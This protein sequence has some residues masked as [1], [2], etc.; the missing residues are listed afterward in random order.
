MAQCCDAWAIGWFAKPFQSNLLS[1]QTDAQE[2]DNE[3]ELERY[4]QILRRTL[5]SWFLETSIPRPLKKALLQDCPIKLSNSTI[6]PIDSDV[7]QLC[8]GVPD[9]PLYKTLAQRMLLL[10]KYESDYNLIPWLL[11]ASDLGFSELSSSM[12]PQSPPPLSRLTPKTCAQYF[13]TSEMNHNHSTTL[14][15][16]A[17]LGFR[18]TIGSSLGLFPPSLSQLMEA[19]NQPHVSP[20]A[21]TSIKSK[22]AKR[23]TI[24]LT[25]AARARAKHAHR[26]QTE[27]V[28]NDGHANPYFGIV[29]GPPST[30]NEQ[31]T[32]IVK[33]MLHEAIWI[34]IHSFSGSLSHIDSYKVSD[35]QRSIRR[36]SIRN[37]TENPP[38]LEIRVPEGYGARWSANW[39][40]PMNPTNVQFRGFLEPMMENGHEN[41]WR[42]F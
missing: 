25:V 22:K 34:N 41:R 15:I 38:V 16:S 18:H 4:T 10:S 42:H 20:S 40:D 9:R 26:T 36:D 5:Q 37:K 8:M 23:E 6:S 17:L 29:K 13:A 32:Q 12:Q 33:K 21:R 28:T 30:Q 1:P 39:S 35:K 31:A 3:E 11:P 2:N 14:L 24:T 7:P 19:A 27:N